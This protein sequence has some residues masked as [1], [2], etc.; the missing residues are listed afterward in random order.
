MCC[1]TITSQVGNK[2]LLQRRTV[3]VTEAA[4]LEG[5]EEQQLESALSEWRK[6]AEGA[7]ASTALEL[8]IA[9]RRLLRSV[10]L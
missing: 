7:V 1:L 4:L 10:H 5:L 2:F 9:E 8:R 6:A 3:Q